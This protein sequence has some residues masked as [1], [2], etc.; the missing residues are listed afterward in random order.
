MDLIELAARDVET[1]EPHCTL[2]EAARRMVDRSVGSLVITESPGGRPIGIVTDRDLVVLLA[3]GADPKVE[4]VASLAPRGLETARPGEGL[5]H[6]AHKMRKH[7][8]RRLPILDEEGR[9]AGIVSMDDLL[10]LFGRGMADLA[11]AVEGE[12]QHERSAKGTP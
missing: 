2:L 6:V 10:V 1:V 8:I 7:G 9:L 11:M 4:T 12:L 3:G 5:Q